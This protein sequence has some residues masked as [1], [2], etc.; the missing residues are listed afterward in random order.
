MSSTEIILM[1]VCVA[2]LLAFLI[3]LFLY[4]KR[5]KDIDALSESVEHY[6]EKGVPTDFSTKDNCFAALQNNFSDLQNLLQ[7]EK[8]N[9]AAQAK[10]NAEFIA[11]ISHQL[12]TPLAGIRLYCEMDCASNQPEHA[13]KELELVEKMENLIYRLLR[14]EKIRSDSYAMDFHMCDTHQLVSALLEDFQPMFPK[15]KY[16]VTGGG[17]LRCDRAWLGEAI[18]NL[19][20]NASEH[21]PEDGNVNILIENSD[22]STIITVSDNGGGVSPDELPALFTRFHKTKNSAPNSAGIGLAITKA[23]VEKHH[24]TISAENRNGGLYVVICL[25]HIDGYITI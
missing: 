18:G 1:I 23:I 2:L 11:D 17:Q 15:K 12:K 25:P 7:L 10:K 6:I 22:N 14:L 19:I 24:G 16:S 4:L 5:K 13:E 3:T 20:K 8:H 9:T 21:T